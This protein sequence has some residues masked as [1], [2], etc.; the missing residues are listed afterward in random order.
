MQKHSFTWAIALATGT[1]IVAFVAHTS[2]SADTLGGLSSFQVQ[3]LKSLDIPIA[4]PSYAPEGFEAEQIIVEFCSSHDT[5]LLNIGCKGNS[6]YKILYQNADRAC[7]EV[8]GDFTIGV[9]GPAGEFAFPVVT[10]LFGETEIGFGTSNGLQDK[11]PSPE[12]LNSPQSHIQTFPAYNSKTKT[13]IV[14][15][16]RTV[17]GKYGCSDNQ[18]LTPLDFKKI[19]QSFTILKE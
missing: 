8:Y 18:S 2:A 17:D 14:Y 15:G 12:Q 10:E 4:V 1:T 7:F 13:P 5:R 3:M 9:G 11:T 16:V 6:G 19:L